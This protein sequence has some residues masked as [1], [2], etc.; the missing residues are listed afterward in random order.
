MLKSLLDPCTMIR[1]QTWDLQA[2]AP[3]KAEQVLEI[4]WPKETGVVG[5]G[6]VDMVCS[7]PTDWLVIA[8]D[9]DAAALL[10]RLDEAFEGSVFRATNAS[11]ALARIEID[12]PEARELLAKGCALD[13]HPSRFPPGCCARTRVAGMP[14]IV[15]CT[16]SS[17]FECIVTMSYAEYLISWLTDAALEFAATP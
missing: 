1:V 12:G 8:D 17:T 11:Q 7:G 14:V 4:T 6:R 5:N 13:L 10:R 3:S 15:W 9:P 2:A 16:Q